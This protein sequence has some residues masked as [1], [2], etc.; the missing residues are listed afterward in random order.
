MYILQAGIETDQLTIV[1]EE[2]AISSYCHNMHL[3]NLSS[4]DESENE[5]MVVDLG[6]NCRYHLLN[7]KIN[8]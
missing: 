8:K 3:D 6:G 4:D 1:Y 5:Y 7:K 2:E